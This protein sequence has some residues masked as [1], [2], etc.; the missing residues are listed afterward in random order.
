MIPNCYSDIEIGIIA[1]LV[2]G[3]FLIGLF[4]GQRRKKK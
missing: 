2:P 3:M 4:F 1:L